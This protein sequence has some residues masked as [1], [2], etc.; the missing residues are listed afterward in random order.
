MLRTMKGTF[1]RFIAIAAIVALGVG[2]LSGLMAMPIDM[3]TTIDEYFDRQNM[4]DLRIVSPLGLTDDDVAAIAA[5][6]GVDEVMP[7]Y[8]TDMFVDAGEKKNI[9]TRIHSLPTGQIEEKEPENYLNRLDVVEG[10]LPIQRNEC[11]LVEGN[12]I[13]GTGPL[14][15]GNTLTIAA[16]N[17]DVSGT[18]ADTEFK[19]VGIVRTSYYFS[20]DRESATIGDGTVA[21]KMY[22][23]EE[24]FSQEAYSEIFATVAGAQALDSASDEYQAAVD[25]VADR[26]EAVSGAR[27]TAR[28][29]EVKTD[30][31]Q[32]LADAKAQL[33]AAKQLVETLEPTVAEGEARLPELAA[34]L[35]ALREAAAAAQETYDAAAAAADLSGKQAAYEAAQSRAN[36]AKS[37]RDAAQAQV[38]AGMSAAGCATE[39]EWL[40]TEP[41]AAKAAID[42]RDAAQ[43][44]LDTANAALNAAQAEYSAAQTAVAPAK[45]ALDTANAQLASAQAAYDTSSAALAAA[46]TQLDTAKAQITEAEPQIAEGEK[47]LADGQQQLAAAKKQVLEAEK[48]IASGETAL[49]LAPGLAQLQLELAQS[50]LDSAKAQYEDGLAQLEDG[51]AELEDGEAEYEKQKKDVEQQLADAEAEIADGEQKLAELEV[52]EWMILDRTS[53]VSASSYLSNVDKLEAITTVFPI[54]FFLVAALVALTTMTRMVEE[55]R[56]Q[57]GTLKALGYKRGQI[58]FKYLFYAWVATLVGGAAGLAFGFTVIPIV[59]W[60]A[61]GTMYTIPGFRCLFHASLAVL[62]VGAALLCTSAATLNAC[63]QTLKE[64]AAQLLLPKAPK[65]GKRIFLERITPVWKRM[66]FT[67]KVTARNLFR[68]KKRFFMTVIGVAGCTA[69]LVTGFGLKDSISD[70]V[71]K[72]FGKVFTYD[73]LVT[74]SKESALKDAGFQA[75][76]DAP[77]Q[78]TSYLPVQQERISLDVDGQSYDVYLFV[79]EDEARL[80]NF[81][82]LHERK[83]GAAVPLTDD[84][85]VITEKFSD[86][87]GLSPGDTLT[88]ENGEGRE[89]TFT[90]TGVAENYVENYVYMTPSVYEDAYGSALEYNSVLGILPD[91]A[92]DVDEAFSTSLL[93]V[94]GVAGL[95][96]MSSMRSSLDDTIASIN[97]VVYVIILCAGMLA[98]V[99]LYNLMNINIT[100]RTKEIATI[101][102]LGFFERE[103]EAY[104]YRESN[105]LT[106]IGMLLGLVGGIFLHMFIMRTVEV[107]MVMFGRDIKPLSFVLSAVL[108]VVFSLLVNLGMK[109]KLRN[110]SMVES[111]KAPE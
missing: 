107:D 47:Q 37:E 43:V 63:G 42:A 92:Q 48:Q 23:G 54:F 13:D 71:S 53:H 3:R 106:V 55:E 41:V 2:L 26:V 1:S 97:Y 77:E 50:K 45:A 99:V 17:G 79:P 94:D 11:V 58:M 76:M 18:L 8:M 86:E 20:V 61:Y 74:L 36:T 68:Y 38:D 78:V 30:T 44:E 6:D 81:I 7:A 98:F 15:V 10:R 85:V 9:V 35:P 87:A 108:T 70:I 69:L 89:G 57:I 66:K 5:V 100:E 29:N 72:Q 75:L 33:A 4:H 24:S 102:V 91:D 14:S 64:W 31:E 52:P 105:V 90:V 88:L 32:E 110:I 39:D 40:A 103:V 101:K 59:I 56:L 82:D 67:H 109:R 51:K 95:T 111:M 46:R 27:C 62:G 96:Q 25:A 83:S 104:V 60:N 21:L 93:E 22:V 16:T 84:G 19:I 28:Y 12:V 65:A 80:D 34:A 49:S 73:F